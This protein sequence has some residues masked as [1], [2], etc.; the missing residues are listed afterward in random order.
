MGLIEKYAFMALSHLDASEGFA[1][2]VPGS[3][4]LISDK[5]II[6]VL[7]GWVDMVLLAGGIVVLELTA[8]GM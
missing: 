5:V 4:V 2:N 6:E 8:G 7:V 1:E 3:A